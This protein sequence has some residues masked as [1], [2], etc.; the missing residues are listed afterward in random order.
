MWKSQVFAVAVAAAGL[1][2]CGGSSDLPDN[3]VG[4]PL[5]ISSA[6]YLAVTQEVLTT[7]VSLV[8]VSELLLGSQVEALPSPIT[9]A[10]NRLPGLWPES[11]DPPLIAGVI[12]TLP[13]ACD[14]GSGTL[15]IDDRDDNDVVS[16]GDVITES[17][18]GCVIDTE[19]LDG[20]IRYSFNS[21]VGDFSGDVFSAQIGLSFLSFRI[22]STVTAAYAL[23]NGDLTLTTNSRAENDF[24]T[25]INAPSYREEVSIGGQTISRTA[26]NFQTR[27]VRAP[28]MAGFDTTVT[29]SGT[30]TS[31]LLGGSSVAITTPVPL[32]RSS[33]SEYPASGALMVTGAANSRVRIEALNDTEVRLELDANGDGAADPPTPV[34]LPWSEFI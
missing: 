24:D 25:E 11:A 13:I 29:A 26:T 7:T 4:P 31:S 12:V 20:S 3:P 34:T 17:Y 9:F 2:A 19:R 1:A 21:L 30:L 27:E 28:T 23:A 18:N 5:L 6:N 22:T 33:P 16:S 8:D 14:A 32:V 15:T 10:R